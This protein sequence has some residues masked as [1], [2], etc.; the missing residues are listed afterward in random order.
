MKK[1]AIEANG[2]FKRIH[3]S[4]TPENWNDGWKDAKGRFRVYRPDCPRAFKS[5]YA[6]RA[7]V[8][9][10]LSKGRV[11]SRG[12]DLHHDN[13]NKLDDRIDNLIPIKHGKHTILHCAKPPVKRVCKSCNRSFNIKKWRLKE[14]S[15]GSYCSQRCYHAA[16]KKTSNAICI[17]CSK[18]FKK[19]SKRH[20][21]CS[22]ICWR[23][24]QE[25]LFP[26]ARAA[27]LRKWIKLNKLN[28]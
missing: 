13:E 1:R 26:G 15:R 3:H 21:Y 4:W 27:Y 28:G 11:H 22:V 18:S 19:Y 12:Y 20:T 8:V 14:K 17:G 6:L 2:R 25:K 16:P 9:Y 24:H 23:K 5:G 10:W 7:H